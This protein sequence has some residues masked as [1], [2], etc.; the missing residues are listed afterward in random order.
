MTAVQKLQ[1]QGVASPSVAAGQAA[2][3][4]VSGLL[5]QIMKQAEVSTVSLSKQFQTLSIEA[6][7]QADSVRHVVQTAQYVESEEG[8]HSFAEALQVLDNVVHD[9]MSADSKE[10]MGDKVA[11]RI[12]ALVGTL[13]EQER[14]FNEAL[15]SSA[16]TGEAIAQAMAS[17]ITDMQFQD[18]VNQLAQNAGHVLNVLNPFLN[19]LPEGEAK[20]F[21]VEAVGSMTMFEHKH[22]LAQLLVQAGVLA[23]VDEAGLSDASDDED[24]IDLF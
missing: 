3:A 11:K 22:A 19:Q 17:T 9:N 4:L 12:Q 6:Q 10:K 8:K 18:R 23:N 5:E 16:E 13:K 20:A 1:E 7:K 21:A 24:D 2:I 14:I 15:E